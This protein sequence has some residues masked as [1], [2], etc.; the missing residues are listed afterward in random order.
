MAESTSAQ[1]LVEM[2]VGRLIEARVFKLATAA[3]VE[4][5]IGAIA[6]AVGRLPAGTNGVLC[7]D[8]RPAE[9]Y[10]QPVTDRL[11]EM[12]QRMNTRLDRVAIVTGAEK[13]TLYMQLRRIAREAHYEAR[14]VY[15]DT[16]PALDHLAMALSADELERA[17][18]F[19]ASFAEN[20][21]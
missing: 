10:P 7:A 17:R 2:H 11:I 20:S 1:Y 19:L 14:Q 9:I 15:Q 4:T 21:R 12:F 13:A 16:P 18:L 8:H 5:Y 3:E 6:A